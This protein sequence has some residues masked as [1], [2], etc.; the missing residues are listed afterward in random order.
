ML[1][2]FFNRLFH[3][4]TIEEIY[5]SI[6]DNVPVDKSELTGID[7]EFLITPSDIDIKAED[8]DN[9]MTPDSFNWTKTIRDGWQFYQ[10]DNDEFSYSWELPGIQMTFNK[11]IKYNKA[12]L[13]A[14]QVVT[15]I[16]KYTKKEIQLIFITT[17]KITRFD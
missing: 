17:D 15:K 9:I 6:L 5:T 14:D 3:K 11:T 2:K 10:I 7:F 4:S 1:Q 8:F 13:I 16:E 12:K